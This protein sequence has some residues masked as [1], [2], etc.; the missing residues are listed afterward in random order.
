MI[1]PKEWL[2]TFRVKCGPGEYASGSFLPQFLPNHQK[3]GIF[4]LVPA[5]SRINR[6]F[7]PV[8]L[9]T[10]KLD[11]TQIKQEIYF[12]KEMNMDFRINALIK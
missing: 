1:S 8:T 10:E 11:G 5:Y 6:M 2:N 7:S 4:G 3:T 12:L 9:I